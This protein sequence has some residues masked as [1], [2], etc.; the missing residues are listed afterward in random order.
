MQQKINKFTMNK[1][2][3]TFIVI[4]VKEISWDMLCCETLS[5]SLLYIVLINKTWFGQLQ[6]QVHLNVVFHNKTIGWKVMF[7]TVWLQY[8]QCLK[9][10]FL[11]TS[12]EATKTTNRFA[13]ISASYE[14]NNCVYCVHNC[15]DHSFLGLPTLTT[16]FPTTPVG[17]LR[18]RLNLQVNLFQPRLKKNSPGL[19]TI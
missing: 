16:L 13:F 6:L 14:R 2:F 5:V 3:A 18:V 7:I 4:A 10:D 11:K 1:V 15:E 9:A 12:N 8:F 19:E 17:M